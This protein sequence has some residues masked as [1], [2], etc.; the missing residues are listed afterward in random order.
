M[1][2]RSSQGRNRE[3]G[4]KSYLKLFEELSADGPPELKKYICSYIKT[5]AWVPSKVS[6]N[7]YSHFKK[8]INI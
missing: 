7:K 8:E 1:S 5:V 2:N 6:I 3:G 4:E